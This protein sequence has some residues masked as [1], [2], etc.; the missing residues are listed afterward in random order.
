MRPG[1]GVDQ[2]R[3]G[4]GVGRL[5]LGRLAVFEDPADDRM[6]R[7]QLLEN[8][9]GGRESLGRPVLPGGRQL[10][11]VEQD[12]AELLGRVDVELGP[13][14]LEDRLL[15]PAEV[16]FE[17]GRK[18][19]KDLPVDLHPDPL[20]V[21][22]DLDQRLLQVPVNGLELFGLDPGPEEAADLES[23]VRVLGGIG[24]DLFDRSP[25]HRHFGLALAAHFIEGDRR[26][27][28]VGRGQPVQVVASPVGLDQVGEDHR[29]QVDPPE[30]DT[31]PGQG[32]W[33]RI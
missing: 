33:R 2:A 30:F 24:R 27:V 22:Q 12:M 29:I 21:G 3:Q 25:V 7:G 16:G 10:E 4:V 17:L 1:L 8:V 9:L 15:E 23:V 31:L 5:Q 20:H 19:S 18:A 26:K 14:R 28:E 13:A 11:L 6:E 32:R